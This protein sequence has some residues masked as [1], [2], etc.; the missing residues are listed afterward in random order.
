MIQLHI[1]ELENQIKWVIIKYK[2]TILT[3]ED[4]LNVYGFINIEEKI[5]STKNSALIV[6]VPRCFYK[7]ALPNPQRTGNFYAK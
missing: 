4:F 5:L 1:Y 6:K 3:Q 2:L 7:K